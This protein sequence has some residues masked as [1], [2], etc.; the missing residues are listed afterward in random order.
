MKNNQLQNLHWP[1]RFLLTQ[2][3]MLSAQQHSRKRRYTRNLTSLK[4]TN[5]ISLKQTFC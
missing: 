3:L 5:L 1:L 2:I 4:Q